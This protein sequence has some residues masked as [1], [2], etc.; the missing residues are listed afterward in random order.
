MSKSSS[1]HH[2]IPKFYAEGF[3]NE[4]RKLFVYDIKTDTIKSKSLP[5]KS[6]FF[7]WDRNTINIKGGKTS[8]IENA[9]SKIDNDCAPIL[10]SIRDEP[11]RSGILDTKRVGLIKYFMIHLLWRIP[12]TDDVFKDVYQRSEI[13]FV[14][15]VTNKEIEPN[16]EI[17]AFLRSQDSEKLSRLDYVSVMIKE[18]IENNEPIE[19]EF[20]A[21]LFDFDS[22]YFVLGDNP[23]VFNGTPK[24]FKELL[25]VEYI[26]PISSKRV[27]CSRKNSKLELSQ[28]QIAIINTIIFIQSKRYV[29]SPNKE[30]LEKS[31]VLYKNL[32]MKTNVG[33]WYRLLFN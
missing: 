26:L 22:D 21:Q 12:A 5:T 7:E 33:E 23:I 13:K 31:I 3:L 2:Y 19:G 27:F 29:A 28:N 25:E 8:E 17:K 24:N 14:N 30:F 20:K 11:N 6:I 4:Q 16:E 9:Y 32:I 10:K 1:R 15:K 18:T